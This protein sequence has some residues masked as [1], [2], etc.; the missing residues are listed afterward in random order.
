M[1]RI[2]KLPIPIPDKV[3]V[4]IDGDRIAVKGPLGEMSRALPERINAV[5]EG[6][7]LVLQRSDES[8]E[9]RSNHGLA[10]SL[11]AN[12]VEG[13]SKG[14][15]RSLEIKGVGYRASEAGKYLR[16]D[17]GYSH[18]IY[19][20]LPE[21]VTAEIKRNIAVTLRGYNKEVLGKAAA[22]IRS[23]RKPEPYKGK[24][25]KYSDEVIVRKVG[26]AGAK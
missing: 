8:R 14:F 10:R 4:K 2:G 7:T 26:K 24:G 13:V 11:T 19:F 1:S 16:F 15:E 6:G 20:E 23:F 5:I 9:A 17:L 12:M 21:G 25:I 18:P 22:T 3:D